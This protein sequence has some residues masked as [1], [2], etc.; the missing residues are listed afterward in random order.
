MPLDSQ[1]VVEYS[2]DPHNLIIAFV[3]LTSK[4]VKKKIWVMFLTFFL[5]IYGFFFFH[6]FNKLGVL[7]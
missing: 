6:I 1:F 3:L 4:Q 7:T 2:S 5:F